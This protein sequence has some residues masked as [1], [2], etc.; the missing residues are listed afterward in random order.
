[1]HVD[2]TRA[3][4][5]GRQARALREADG[6]PARAGR[7][8]LRRRRG[9]TGSC[10]ARRSCGATTRRPR[11][12]R[13][14]LD[15]GA[16]GDV[17]LVRACFSFVARRR[18]RRAPGPG[19]R[20]RRA[21]GRRLLLRQRRAAGRGGEPVSVSAR[22]RHR[23]D[24]RRPAPD[25]RCCASTAT[26]S[27]TIDC[28]LDIAGARRAR[29]RRL[30]GPHR[31]SPTRG[32]R[33]EP[34]IV[35]RARL[36]ARGRRARAGRQLPP[37]ARGRGRRDRAA[38]ARRCSAA[39]TRSARRA[40]SR[41]CIA[42][43]PRAARWR[44]DERPG[45]L[46]VAIAG[47]GLAGEVFHAPLVAATDGLALVAVTTS[48][49]APRGAG[50][51]RLPRRRTSRPTPTR[52]CATSPDLD[53]LVV[54]TPNR[55]HVPIARAALARGIAGRH[56]QAA[57]RRRRGRRRARR[58]RSPRRGVPFTVFQNRRWDGD[59]LTVAADRASP[60]SSATS[61]ASSRASSASAR[62][63]TPSAWRESADAAEGGGL[64]LD[65]GAH[66]VDQALT[67]FGVPRRVY[68]EIDARRPG[69]QVDDD[70]FV[71]LEHAGGVR[72]HLWMSAV[73]PL[74]GRSLRVERD[75]RRASRRRAWTRRRTSSPRGCGRA[76]RT[77]ARASR[78]A[79]PT[80]RGERCDADR[81]RRL[82]ALLRGRA[83]RAAR[84]GADARRPARQRRRRCA[85][86]RR[87]GAARA[88]GAVI[89]TTRGGGRAHEDEPWHLGDGPD[90]HPL[91]PGRLQARARR[92]AAPPST[93]APRSPGS[94]A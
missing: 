86:S 66:L 4:A 88:T 3:R 65:L 27:A 57:R 77:G 31:C 15:E 21:D 17:R 63:S 6:P 14:L 8:R 83:R 13:E 23:A 19:A 47:Y 71:A 38:S 81:A 90:G 82:R 28:G 7:A 33:I 92:R 64:L 89:D 73:A 49:A 2:W 34:R 79:S 68:A 35:R 75:A 74:G 84:R 72:S 41:R 87:R 85:S 32:T 1:M 37:R 91:Q 26:C 78:R 12:L 93:C 9:G 36:R 30:R 10:S 59:F 24:R 53:L 50:A 39:P 48:D 45:A 62:R 46:R 61:R 60:A 22:G 70:V 56:G 80:R 29:D 67:L 55:L 20:R 11:R 69:A 76:T 40:R 44:S 58:R 43:P 51:R 94:R 54:A 25:R 5:A 18:R 42:R 52:C 16:I